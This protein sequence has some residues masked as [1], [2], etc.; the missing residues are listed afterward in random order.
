[1]SFRLLF[2]LGAVLSLA[3]CVS[4][5]LRLSTADIADDPAEC[6]G[7]AASE[8]YFENTPVRLVDRPVRLA[9]RLNTFYPTSQSLQFVDGV[10]RSWLSP[11]GTLTDGASIPLIFQPIVGNPRT[12]EFVNAAAL[13]DAWCGIGNEDGAVYQSRTWQEV[14]RMFYDTLIV[15]GTPEIKAKVMFAAVWLGGPRWRPEEKGDDLALERLPTFIRKDAMRQTK[16]YIERND[17][18]MARLMVYLDGQE[19]QMIDRAARLGDGDNE[20]VTIPPPPEPEPTEE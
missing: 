20:R 8:C 11:K 5:E 17:P 15:G 12:Q 3:A 1:M 19:R 14:H 13:H 16:A 4:P 10:Q 9:G 18:D 2:T 7:S 6:R